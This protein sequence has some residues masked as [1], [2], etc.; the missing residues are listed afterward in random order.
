MKMDSLVAVLFEVTFG[1]IGALLLRFHTKKSTKETLK[2]MPFLSV[3]LGLLVTG[4][5]CFTAYVLVYRK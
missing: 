1:F 4:V 3:V 2:E 5:F